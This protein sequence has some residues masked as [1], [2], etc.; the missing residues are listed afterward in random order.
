MIAVTRGPARRAEEPEYLSAWNTVPVHAVEG[1]D[2]D[3][4]Y[5]NLVFLFP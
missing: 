4:H 1:P 2:H 5:K 3:F